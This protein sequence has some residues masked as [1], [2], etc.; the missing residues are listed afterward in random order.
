MRWKMRWQGVGSRRNHIASRKIVILLIGF[1]CS[2]VMSLLLLALA[3]WFTR[4]GRVRE[5]HAQGSH[6]RQRAYVQ[7]S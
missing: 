7:K 3:M 4:G 1:G 6:V 5:S 2:V